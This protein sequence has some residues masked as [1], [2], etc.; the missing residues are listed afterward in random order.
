M[1]K[2]PRWNLR[3]S[4][5][6]LD[7]THDLDEDQCQ[8]RLG[9]AAKTQPAVSALNLLE[10]VSPQLNTL[11]M[12]E[13][14]TFN[15][16]LDSGAA[17]HVVDSVETPGY[18]VQE[19]PGSK[20]G[21]CFV[22]ANGERIPNRGEV[23]LDMKSGTVPL[24]STFQVSSISKPLWSVGKLC[25][26]GYKVEFNK[27]AAIITHVKSGTKIGE[28]ERNQGLYIGSMQLKNPNFQRQ[29]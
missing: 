13:Y 7:V 27:S 5:A 26:A 14:T 9:E 8:A 19:S 11:S 21:S 23:K 28:F 24:R 29:P 2:A 1:K 25:D 20:A 12:Q 6:G 22:A 18:E 10:S 15:V 17:D 3:Q 4:F 16:V